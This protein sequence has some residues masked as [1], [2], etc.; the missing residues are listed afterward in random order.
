[1]E[2]PNCGSENVHETQLH[3][4]SRGKPMRCSD[5]F[6]N[7]CTDEGIKIYETLGDWARA[8]SLFYHQHPQFDMERF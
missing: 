7:W 2:C 6:H 8:F 4:C 5:C 1:M 3:E